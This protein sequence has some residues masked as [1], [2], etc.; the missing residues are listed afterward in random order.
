MKNAIPFIRTVGRTTVKNNAEKGSF[1]P[2]MKI[3]I[4]KKIDPDSK[5]PSPAMTVAPSNV[6]TA[7]LTVT[8]TR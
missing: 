3:A 7:F 5:V 6:V 4:D 2:R 8:T 1:T